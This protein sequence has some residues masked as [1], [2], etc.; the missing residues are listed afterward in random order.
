LG[1]A[2]Q[3]PVGADQPDCCQAGCDG[4]A[5]QRGRCDLLARRCRPADV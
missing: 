4:C 3:R 1:N 5:G 2:C